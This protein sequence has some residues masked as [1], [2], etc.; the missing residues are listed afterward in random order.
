[1]NNYLPPNHMTMISQQPGGMGQAAMSKQ[2][3]AMLSY[4]NTKPLSHF[5]AVEHGGQRMTPPM[6]SAGKSPMMPYMQ[7]PAGQ[8]R[9]RCPSAPGAGADGGSGLPPDGGAEA[10]AADEAEAEPE[11]VARR[12]AAPRPVAAEGK[13]DDDA[14]GGDGGSQPRGPPPQGGGGSLPPP[15]AGSSA[16]HLHCSA[17]TPAGSRGNRGPLYAVSV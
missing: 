14:S 9:G 4:S 1:M 17:I 3:A 12:H 5:S 8:G 11:H 13:T 15:R 10:H 16:T 6:A 2:Q 7:A